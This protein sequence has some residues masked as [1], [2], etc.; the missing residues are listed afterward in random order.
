MKILEPGK[1][2]EKW[3]IQ[4]RCTGWGNGDRG[5]D[6]L[7]EVEYEDLRFYAGQEFPWRTSD[8]AVSFKC[9]CCGQITD[10]GMNDWPKGYKELPAFT[11]EWREAKPRSVA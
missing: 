8:P 11:S 9:P 3:A 5:C 2:G 6:A 1:V 10:L 4:H 7:L